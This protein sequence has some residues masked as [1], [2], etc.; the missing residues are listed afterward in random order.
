MG[1]IVVGPAMTD[2]ELL[3]LRLTAELYNAIHALGDHHP[4]DM[5]E[6][7]RDIH[8]IQARVM[9]RLARRVHPEVFS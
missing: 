3:V 6:L 4:S 8:S 5:D 1:A 2:G 7:A 9:A